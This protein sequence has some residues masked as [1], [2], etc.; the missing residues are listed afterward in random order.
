ML[1]KE[2]QSQYQE[3][4]YLILDKYFDHS[5]MDTLQN[6]ALK[7]VEDFDENST[8]S[9]FS[10][11]NDTTS[12]DRYFLTSDDAIKCFF[13]EDAF[14]RDGELVQSK[15]LSINKIGHALHKYNNA[16]NAFC[17][18]PDIASIA[19]SIGQIHPEIRQ[20]MYIFKQPKIGGKV[21]WH[22]DATYFMTYPTSV[23]TFWI[24]I[25]DANK[26]NGCLMVTPDTALF[27]IKEQFKRFEDDTTR[28][29]ALSDVQWPSESGAV[30]LE[31]QKGS[32]VVFNGQLP[33]YSNANTSAK[34]RHA[35][36]LHITCGTTRYDELNWLRAKAMKLA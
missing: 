9:I 33:H 10:T 15:S 32:L 35:V 34:S 12:R 4:G 2:Q 26:Q 16:F 36:T 21:R 11:E 17:Q 7:I 25:E 1:S 27:P 13:E 3:Q 6:A 29:D 30:A 31:V 18:R 20:S 14:G 28:L 22:Q 24:A 5:V 23:I 19:K 8:R